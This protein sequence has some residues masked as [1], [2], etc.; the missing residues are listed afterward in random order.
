MKKLKQNLLKATLLSMFCSTAL[1][2]QESNTFQNP[3]INVE[4]LVGNRGVSFQMIID[5]QIKS[6]PQLGFFSVTD[7]NSDWS[8]QNLQDHMTQASLTYKVFNGLKVAAGFHNTPV[9]GIRPSASL[10]YTFKNNNWLIIAVPRVDLSKDANLEGLALIEYKPKI[11]DKWNLYT[12][13]QGVY[14]HTMSLDLHARSYFRARLGLSY[15]EFAFGVGSN[16]EY[17]GPLKHNENNVGGFVQI[18]LF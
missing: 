8:E 3:P 9:T 13:L 1:L 10:I 5:K 4:T 17:Y 12:R 2:A 15:K 7:I 18:L 14:T 11:N 16:V 6:I